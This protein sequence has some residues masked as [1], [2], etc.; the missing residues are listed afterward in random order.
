M[1]PERHQMNHY[2]RRIVVFW[3]DLENNDPSDALD[4]T[5]EGLGH[6]VDH[7]LVSTHSMDKS[8]KV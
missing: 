8:R 1:L 5:K 2:S 7:E 6:I 3:S 4:N